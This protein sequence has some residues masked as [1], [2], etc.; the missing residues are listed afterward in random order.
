MPSLCSAMS[1]HLQALPRRAGARRRSTSTSAR[2]DPCAPRRERRRQVDARS[3][4][5]PAPS[6]RMPAAI[7]FDGQPVTFASP[8]AGP[9]SRHRHD[10][11]GVQPAPD[12]VGGRERLHRPRAGLTVVRR[13]ARMRRGAN[14]SALPAHRPRARARDAL[15][16]DLSVAEQQMVEIA[17]ALSM[18]RA[19]RHGRADVG[20]E[21]AARSRSCSGSSAI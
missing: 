16:R 11:P 21:P 8:H 6:R 13:L 20:A 1:G 2:R 15:V 10:L 17:R 12:H 5:C 18:K 4:S 9:G 7:E 3:R 19:H 14:P